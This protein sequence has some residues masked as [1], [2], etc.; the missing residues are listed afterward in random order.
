MRGRCPAG[1]PQPI[2]QVLNAE[3]NKALA[4][5]EVR[6]RLAQ[7]GNEVVGGPPSVLAETIAREMPLWTKV[8]RERN[9]K[10]D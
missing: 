7:L 10:L 6:D 1:L 9:L 5:P 4:L 2:V 8:M 3:I